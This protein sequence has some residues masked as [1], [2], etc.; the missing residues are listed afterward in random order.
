MIRSVATTSRALDICF[1]LAIDIRESAIC[2]LPCYSY[3]YQGICQLL[4]GLAKYVGVSV[5]MAC[6]VVFK[7]WIKLIALVYAG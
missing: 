6:C 3:Q 5:Y 4:S 2:Y 1:T 7:V